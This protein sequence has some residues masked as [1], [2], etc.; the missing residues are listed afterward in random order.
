MVACMGVDL[1]LQSHRLC[2][3]CYCCMYVCMYVCMCV[4]GSS[5]V[6]GGWVGGGCLLVG[7][8]GWSNDKFLSFLVGHLC[9]GEC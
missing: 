2:C 5:V 4:F 8:K 7:S 9:H 6:G 1:C 3:W